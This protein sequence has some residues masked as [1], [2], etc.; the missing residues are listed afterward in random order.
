VFTHVFCLRVSL[1]SLC[2]HPHCPINGK[3]KTCSQKVHNLKFWVSNEPGTHFCKSEGIKSRDC[4][5]N[6]GEAVSANYDPEYSVFS[7]K[8]N[9]CLLYRSRNKLRNRRRE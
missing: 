9:L 7:R 1:M 4:F 5:A 3:S 6:N 8:F 2:Y